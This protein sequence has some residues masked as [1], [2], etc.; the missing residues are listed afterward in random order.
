[1]VCRAGGSQSETSA[2]DSAWPPPTGPRRMPP[3][4]VS[5]RAA[6]MAGWQMGA[7]M[8]LSAQ[9]RAHCPRCG[10]KPRFVEVARPGCQIQCTPET[11]TVSQLPCPSCGAV[12][13]WATPAGL[14]PDPMQRHEYRCWHGMGWTVRVIDAGVGGAD[15]LGDPGVECRCHYL[16]PGER[17]D[18]TQLA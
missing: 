17:P 3:F 18:V 16:V 1:M 12:P 6:R 15:P 8:A 10:A 14:Y 2:L 5:M 11:T 4:P 13:P 7:S 9:G